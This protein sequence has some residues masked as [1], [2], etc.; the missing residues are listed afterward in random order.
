MRGVKSARE[1]T[2]LHDTCR[3]VIPSCRNISFRYAPAEDFDL[4]RRYSANRQFRRTVIAAIALGL[5]M[6]RCADSAFCQFAF[7]AA[8]TLR[9]ASAA[10]VRGMGRVPTADSET[11]RRSPG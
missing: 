8:P 11:S 7:P 1:A 4:A 2:T 10:V 6:G 5:A 9:N 3:D